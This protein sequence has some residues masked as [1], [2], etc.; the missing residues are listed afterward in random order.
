MCFFC[1]KLFAETFSLL[2]PVYLFRNTQRNVHVFN[3]GI[4]LIYCTDALNQK[5]TV[6]ASMRHMMR[7]RD[8]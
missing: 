2:A 3:L 8:R 7:K 6:T 5:K 4:T 1:V